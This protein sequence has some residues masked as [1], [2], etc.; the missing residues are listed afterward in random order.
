MA[1]GRVP[2]SVLATNR[3]SRHISA[4]RI[5]LARLGNTS[6][7]NAALIARNTIALEAV[8]DLA[9]NLNSGALLA[10]RQALLG[11]TTPDH[12]GQIRDQLV[13]IGGDSPVTAMCVSPT[14]RRNFTVPLSSGLLTN[15]N[16]HFDALNENRK[17]NVVPIIEDV[18]AAAHNAMAN[19]QV[20]LHDLDQIRDSILSAVSRVTKNLLTVSTF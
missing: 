12:A 20:L 2:K 10:M 7:P 19:T 13:S 16:A 3:A 18:V 6:R 1:N 8:L 14:P 11:E 15:T 9:D 17:E 4:R 5:S